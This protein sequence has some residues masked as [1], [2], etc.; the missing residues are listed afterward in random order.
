MDENT[1]QGVFGSQQIITTDADQAR[2]I[3]AADIDGDGDL[4][5]FSV[6]QNDGK[7]AWYENTDGL[8]TFG[9]QQLIGTI[10]IGVLSL[11]AADFDSDTDIDLVVA[12]ASTDTVTW[13]ENTNGQGAFSGPQLISNTLDGP[14]SVYA[15][16]L[17]GDLDQ[18]VAVANFTGDS[19]VWFENTNGQGTF[20]PAQVISLNTI[21][22]RNI[23]AGDLDGDG[24]IDILS[25]SEG[26]NKI[27]W[28]ENTDGIGIFGAQQVIDIVTGNAAS[29]YSIDFDGDSD[30]D[31]VAT[32]T[33]AIVW[34][35]NL[36]GLGNFSLEQLID[37]SVSFA[38]FVSAADL[39]GDSDMDVLSGDDNGVF[40][41]E[42]QHPLA[43]ADHEI[44]PI[45][46]YPNPTSGLV[47]LQHE[48]GIHIRFFTLFNTLGQR[49][50]RED[51]ITVLDL[52]SLANGVYYVTVATNTGTITTQLVKE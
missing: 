25:A 44:V 47:Y 35:E 46:W 21:A 43:V 42:N 51:G 29:V 38:F 50:L 39:D 7:V 8:G 24:D 20:G 41:Y 34:Y 5:I 11:S 4:D 48:P 6:S 14:I 23:S 10:S 17:D 28:Y 1:G 19:I 30:F 22:A 13:Y 52:S 45:R 3:A 15:A 9:P 40:W 37:N 26:D 49:I 33:N 12:N 36:D 32:T 27:A 18:D 16:D 2:D 31:V